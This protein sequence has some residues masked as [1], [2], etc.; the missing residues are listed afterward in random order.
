MECKGCGGVFGKI[1]KDDMCSHCFNQAKEEEYVNNSI[2]YDVERQ[3]EM[4]KE[5]END[6]AGEWPENEEEN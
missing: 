6:L 3:K 4:E 5:I 1:I 2:A